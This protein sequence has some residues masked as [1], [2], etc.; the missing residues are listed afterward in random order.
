MNANLSLYL[1]F[2]QGGHEPNHEDV[3]QGS[4]HR[5]QKHRLGINARAR[6]KVF[7]QLVQPLLH[8]LMRRGEKKKGEMKYSV[9]TPEI[10]HARNA[11]LKYVNTGSPF[12]KEGAR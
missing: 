5:L 11:H 10:K 12:F 2:E 4:A 9:Q 3:A 7:P 6:V 8:N 1:L